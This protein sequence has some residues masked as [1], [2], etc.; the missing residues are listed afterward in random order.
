MQEQGKEEGGRGGVNTSN[1]QKLVTGFSGYLLSLPVAPS[2]ALRCLACG[3]DGAVPRAVLSWQA[4]G[5]P[6]DPLSRPQAADEEKW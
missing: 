3:G 5:L 6:A 1:E 2:V 4:R